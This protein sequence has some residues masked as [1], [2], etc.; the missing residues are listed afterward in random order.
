MSLRGGLYSR[1]ASLRRHSFFLV[2]WRAFGGIS[3][4]HRATVF[5]RERTPGC[6]AV[7]DLSDLVSTPRV[8]VRA[9]LTFHSLV[10]DIHDRLDCAPRGLVCCC[11]LESRA[12]VLATRR[13]YSSSA[14][15]LWRMAITIHNESIRAFFS[16]DP[17][18]CTGFWYRFLRNYAV[19]ANSPL[20]TAAVRRCYGKYSVV[21]C[22]VGWLQFWAHRYH[23]TQLRQSPNTRSNLI[24][25]RPSADG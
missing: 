19:L 16:G 20:S 11:G 4:C 21:T 10:V 12:V 3:C 23:S 7:G 5:Q 13:K 1:S 9:S 8:V 2:R 24:V 18:S 6:F 22:E 15:G 17:D 25:S 14:A